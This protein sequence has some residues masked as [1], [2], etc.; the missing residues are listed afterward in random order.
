MELD[1]FSFL[2]GALDLVLSF[3][4]ELN[5]SSDSLELVLDLESDSASE[6]DFEPAFFETSDL[7]LLND[8][9]LLLSSDSDDSCF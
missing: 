9:N 7:L 3:D 5:S 1:L 4:S 2:C 8:F 6:F